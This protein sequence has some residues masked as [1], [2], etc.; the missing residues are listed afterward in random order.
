MGRDLNLKMGGGLIREKDIE[1]QTGEDRRSEMEA[2]TGVLIHRQAKEC[3]TPR[4]V[5]RGKKGSSPRG[6]GE[7]VTLL[8]HFR[9]PASTTVRE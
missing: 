6:F 8:A 4:E 9:F 5:G 1:T 7:S 3:H 2:E